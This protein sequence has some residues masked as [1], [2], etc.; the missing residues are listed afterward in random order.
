MGGNV[1]KKP[2][3]CSDSEW[4]V[5]RNCDAMRRWLLGLKDNVATYLMDLQV[6]PALAEELDQ[7][8]SAQF[9]WEFHATASTSSRII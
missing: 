6:I 3:Q 4:I 9:A 1:S 2:V 7:L 5:R 8:F